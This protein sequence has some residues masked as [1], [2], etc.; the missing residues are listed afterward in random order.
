[1][2][3]NFVINQVCTR[4]DRRAYT[5]R[6]GELLCKKHYW[7][8]KTMGD[9][10]RCEKER[11]CVAC[12]EIKPLSKFNSWNK[13]GGSV[14]HH[15]NCNDC[16]SIR[17]KKRY[18]TDLEYQARNRA[19][20][21]RSAKKR[22]RSSPE[23]RAKI[24]DRT[25]RRTLLKNYGITAEDYYRMLAEQQGTCAL[26]HRPCRTGHRLAVDHDHETGVVRGLLC[27]FC[28][29]MLGLAEDDVGLFGRAIKYIERGKYAIGKVG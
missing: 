25:W 2:T 29:T 5:R 16:V 1:M 14:A 15:S 28:N 27:Y 4:C 9:P 3:S 10:L 20:S 8:W 6:S 24:S 26:C 12:K 7:S 19:A 17:Q 18:H 21:N 13:P 23:L 22:Y 11:P